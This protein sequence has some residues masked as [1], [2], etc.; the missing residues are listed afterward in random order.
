MSQTRHTARNNRVLRIG[1]Y[2]LT[3]SKYRK[4]LQLVNSKI[5]K[6][7]Y[8]AEGIAVCF[9]NRY[10]PPQLHDLDKLEAIMKS[11]QKEIGL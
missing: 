2:F 1:R 7:L 8:V 5:E 3:A 6:R 11:G 4:M 9:M 10:I